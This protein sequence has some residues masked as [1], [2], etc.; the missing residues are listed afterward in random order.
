VVVFLY[1]AYWAFD[2]RKSLAVPLFRNQ[3]LGMGLMSLLIALSILGYGVQLLGFSGNG[4]VFYLASLLNASPTFVV[5][6]YWIDASMLAAR[7]SDPLLRDT[8]RWSKLRIVLW[9]VVA[10]SFVSNLAASLYFLATIGALPFQNSLGG[11]PYYAWS[12]SNYG[13]I[14]LAP[15]VGAIAIP[16]ITYRSKDQA[17]R[18]HFKWLGLA[19]VFFVAFFVLLGTLVSLGI[20]PVVTLTGTAYCLYRSAKSLAPLNR[21]SLDELRVVAA[22]RAGTQPGLASRLP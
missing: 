11:L 5:I 1:A 22:F 9:G 20:E 18:R 6:F 19:F 8:L 3:A 17:L 15:L 2:I 14:I 16:V 4:I 12:L 21:L 10:V 7:R 13:L